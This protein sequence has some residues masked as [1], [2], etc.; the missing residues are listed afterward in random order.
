MLLPCI[1]YAIIQLRSRAILTLRS[2]YFIGGPLLL[3]ISA[4]SLV[5]GVC[6]LCLAAVEWRRLK[7]IARACAIVEDASPTSARAGAPLKR[8]ASGA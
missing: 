5:I 4:V 8:P 6:L 2:H 1:G 7:R 3:Y